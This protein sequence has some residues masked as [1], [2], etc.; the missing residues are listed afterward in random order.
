MMMLLIVALSASMA[1]SS[2]SKDKDDDPS[3]SNSN[4][5]VGTWYFVE[6]DGELDYEDCFVFKSNGTFSWYDDMGSYRFNEKT[7]MLV[8]DWDEYGEDDPIYVEFLG[9][10]MI[11][12]EDYGVYKKK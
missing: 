7:S 2:C 8:L 9:K 12:L 6:D 4:S 10:N 11:Y 1:I 3:S 5:I